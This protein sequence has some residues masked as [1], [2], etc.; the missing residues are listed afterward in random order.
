MVH[1]RVAPRRGFT[2][3]S[4]RVY[5]VS[6]FQRQPAFPARHVILL[7]FCAA[8]LLT[9]LARSRGE[10]PSGEK[11]SDEGDA[12]SSATSDAASSLEQFTD[13]IYPLLTRGDTSCLDCHRSE[14]TSNLVLIGEPSDDFLVLLQNQYFDPQYPDSLL[15]RVTS[16]DPELR[17]P[18][19]GHP[20]SARDIQLLRSFLRELD[21]KLDPDADEQFP[22]S[23]LT[24]YEGDEEAADGNQFI[25]YTQLQGKVRTIF[26]DDWVRDGRD[27]F[28]ESV[29]MFGGAD[30]E[31]R[32][33]ETDEPSTSFLSGLT[34]LAADVCQRAYNRGTG[35]F[36]DRQDLDPPGDR[37]EPDA[38]YRAEIDRL[39]QAILFRSPSEAELQEA[40]DLIREV[41][42][43][44]DEIRARGY[45]LSFRVSAI[46]PDTKL[47][48]TETIRIPISGEQRGRHQEL[49]DQSTGEETDNRRMVRQTLAR[50]FEFEKGDTV[51]MVVRN[52]RSVGN[53]SFA[54]VQWKRMGSD[55]QETIE[56][57]HESVR[58]DG[59]WSIKSKGGFTSFEDG[60]VEKG[61]SHIRI[62]LELEA[63]GEYELSVL[64]RKDSANATQVLV[65]VEGEGIVDQ[66]AIA[67]TVELPDP[68][69]A[70]FH[71]DSSDDTQ[72][73]ADLGAWFQ[74]GEG[75]YVEINNSGTRDRVTAA[76][77][78][79]VPHDDDGEP[80]T[81]D[82]LDA[83]GSDGWTEYDSGRFR[84][85]NTKGTQLHDDGENKGE[86]Y[87][88]YRPSTQVEDSDD[89]KSDK[90]GEADGDAERWQ[91][92]TFYKPHIHYPGKRDHETQTPVIIR[93]Q[94]SSPIVHVRYPAR[95]RADAGLRMDASSSYT[96]QRS[97]LEFQWEQIG[98]PS[99]EWEGE[100]S[101][102]SVTFTAPRRR[103]QQAAWEALAQALMRHP[104]FLFTRP[105]SLEQTQD[106]QD[107]K[108]LQLVKIA[109]DL[110]GRA[111]TASEL[112]RLAEGEPLA[113]LVD[114]Y[115]DSQEFR[116][117]YFHRVRLYLESQ[118]NEV[119]DEP[120][121][122]WCYVA[123][124]DRPFQEILTADYTVDAEF[125]KQSRPEY[126]GRT[127]L[128]TTKGFMEGKPGL[129][130]YNYAAQVSM[131]FLGYVFE[132]PSDII[133]QRDGITP[134]GTTDR[135]SACYSC[136]KTLTPLAMQR[137]FWTD[138][139]RFRTEDEDGLEI[140]AS[141]QGLVDEYPFPGV[142][143]EAFA[144]QAVRKERFIRTMI[145]THFN[146]YFGRSL[147]F[148]TDERQL[149]QT[150]WDHVHED[151]FT[152]RGMIRKLMSQP[153]YLA[154][155]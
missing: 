122:L 106:V 23:L 72:P 116:D 154:D 13:S 119:E 100:R 145:N 43:A 68:G 150:L 3:D 22:A 80:F 17:M 4:N 5:S 44:G 127:G 104:D 36:A 146:F 73:F 134:A 65:E 89:G 29:A 31:T 40:F 47:K 117:F 18:Q 91:S 60:D 38:G 12:K 83:E 62:P 124:N 149:Y 7:F 107:R 35:P 48:T 142:G 121:R 25:T 86:R 125:E 126:H 132:V 75:D 112:R 42:D 2:N 143:M 135:T 45:R 82:S 41:Y 120:V 155:S 95:G 88:R 54:G 66:L 64:W 81:I 109:A 46:D 148:R 96:V 118:G 111:P 74:F 50:R 51:R 76:A 128:L 78:D 140:D 85:Y 11:P 87:L 58:A 27:L 137:Q 144:T 28:A 57:D 26:G 77:V 103:P 8:V 37:T 6:S 63:D 129:P 84:A 98:G 24:P 34:M 15:A 55:E 133:D 102:A 101:S 49:I 16:D 1:P 10:T 139:G 110:V 79:F 153:E 32:F 130:H 151:G 108:Q 113:G 114:S 99:V 56:A 53:V 147:R 93:A 52:D 70:R 71:Y 105:P 21:V 90:D 141:D 152:I 138:D 9:P 61:N 14:D 94:R 136:H 39:Y 97:R 30:F 69:E 67:P 131:M 33:T 20:W 115:L 19:D 92:E 123:F 59:A